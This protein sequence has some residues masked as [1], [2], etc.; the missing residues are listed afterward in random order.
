[1][2][3]RAARVGCGAVSGLAIAGLTIAG[4]PARWSALGFAVDERGRC[5]LG[6][7]VL[8][9]GAVGEGG[10]VGWSLTAQ[11]LPEDIDGIPTR[12]ASAPAGA[13]PE[14]PNSALA[15]DHV[16]LATPDVDRSIAA[17]ERV[18]MTL[19]R[20]RA[21]EG[22]AGALRQAFFRHGEAI[23]EVVGPAQ[24]EG[25]DPARLWGVTLVINS[26][27]SAAAHLGER[28][29]GWR[30]AVQPGRRIATV[31]RE[32]GLGVRL[33]LMTPEPLPGAPR[34]VADA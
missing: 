27:E 34:P 23:L 1:M 22:A 10:I 15:V 20:E 8:E 29:G 28:L 3:G 7:T 33:A 25:G 11:R 26:P 2:P 9:L 18:G 21:S 30:D 6:A 4:D 14:H 24:P 31:R 32:A 12:S 17:L 19:R 16:V 5:R 13:P